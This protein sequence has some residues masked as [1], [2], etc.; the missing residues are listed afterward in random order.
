MNYQANLT[1]HRGNQRRNQQSNFNFSGNN[2]NYSGRQSGNS[3]GN[4]FGGGNF[5]QTMNPS[6]KIKG[7]NPANEEELKEKSYCWFR[8]KKNFVPNPMTNRRSAYVA[9]N[10]GHMLLRMEG[11]C[12]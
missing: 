4:Q 2:N 8:F 3:N 6:D 1:Y 9:E 12:H 11:V 7:K 5:N 10:E